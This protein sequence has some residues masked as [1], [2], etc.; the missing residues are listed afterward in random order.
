M[1]MEN[2]ISYHSPKT[3]FNLFENEPVL[4]A[5]SGGADSSALL[6]LLVNDAKENGFMIH[7]AHFNHGIRG[8]DADRDAQFCKMTAESYDI[9]FHLSCADIPA[10]AKQNGNS[11]EQEAREQR[12]AFFERVMRE[13]GIRLLLTAHHAEDNVESILLHALR[14]SGITG[15]CGIKEIRPLTNDGLLIAR[16]LLL[17]EKKDILSYCEE[18]N[19]RF[20]TDST[21]EDISYAR[22]FIRSQ[23]TPKMRELQPNLSTVL[24]RLA[25]SAAEADDFI[26]AS[27][28][29]FIE[30]ECQNGIPTEK[31]NQLFPI[32]K[33]STL[34]ILFKNVSCA[35]LERVHIDAIIS[36]CEKAVPHSSI[37][38]PKKMKAVIEREKLCF[39]NED[40]KQSFDDFS[41]P[42]KVGKTELINK[43]V[44]NIEKNPTDAPQKNTVCLDINADEI[45]PLAHFRSKKEGDTI[46]TGK[47][48]KKVKKLMCDKKIPLEQ[49]NKLPILVLNEEILWIPTVAVCDR[50]KKGKINGKSDFFRITVTM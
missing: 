26:T 38:L 35:T 2:K 9:P 30:K 1:N 37:S 36:L 22:N 47:L 16:P 29:E 31:F 12:Y 20:V 43:I 11:I 21:N 17:A 28:N 19:I 6:H 18:N 25:E 39:V 7:A 10:L 46:H 48:N 23:L 14:G 24:A 42:F 34:S 33:A 4:L 45:S 27:A 13:N 8:E 40:D 49:R 3:L 50:I 41:V 5:F 15:L 32:V 44:I